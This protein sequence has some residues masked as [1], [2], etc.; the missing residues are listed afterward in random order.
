MNWL[1]ID[2]GKRAVSR[3]KPIMRV[4]DQEALVKALAEQPVNPREIEEE[5]KRIER[6]RYKVIK[7]KEL[8]EDQQRSKEVK[9]RVT[10]IGL[11]IIIFSTDET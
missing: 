8:A 6:H 10:T 11:T 3:G 4:H 7:Q 9:D 1:I 2:D 5:K